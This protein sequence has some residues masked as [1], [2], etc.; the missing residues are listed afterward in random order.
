MIG[1]LVTGHGHF[2]S[3]ITSALTLICG[4][5]Q[6]YAYVDFE[7]NDSVEELERK[8]NVAFEQLQHCEGILVF[9]DL[10]GGSPFKSA[11]VISSD[12]EHV[13]VMA[14]SNLPVLIET[15]MNRIF[16][17]DVEA[18]ASSALQTAKDQVCLYEYIEVEDVIEEDGI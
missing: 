7:A 9:A 6:D 16:Q 15:N 1:M 3:G 13:K 18:M 17:N 2:A 11:V 12:K 10:L 14:G 5:L 8:L 4:E